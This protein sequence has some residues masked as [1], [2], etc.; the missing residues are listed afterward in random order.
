M[1]KFSKSNGHT[2]KGDCTQMVSDHE[3]VWWS[4]NSKLFSFSEKPNWNSVC[5]QKNTGVI[6]IKVEKNEHNYPKYEWDDEAF[7]G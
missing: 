2:C 5:C 1:N 7:K 3:S 4:D 6:E